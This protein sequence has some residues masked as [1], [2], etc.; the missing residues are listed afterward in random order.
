MSLIYLG[1]Y[2]KYRGLKV[3]I[4]DPTMK[5][6]V[7]DNKFYNHRDLLINSIRLS[8]IHEIQQTT[9]RYVGISC[10]SGEVEEVK[11][12]IGDIRRYSSAKIVVGG[13]HPTLNPLEFKDY[14]DE[15]VVGEGEVAL[16]N[17][18]MGNPPEEY[19][20]HDIESISH[21]DYSLIDVDYYTRPNPYSIRGMFLSTSY[22]LASRGCPASCKFCVAPRLRPYFGTGRYRDVFS[23]IK[24]IIHLRDTYHI[25]GFYFLDDYFTLNKKLVLE[26]CKYMR[27]L[28]TGLV[29]ACNSKVNIDE[30]LIE[31]VASAGC[32]QMDF[33]VERGSD[34][35][36][37]EVNK[38]QTVEQI[39]NTFRLC[40]KYGVRTF[41]NMLVNIKGETLEDYDDII[42]LLNEIKPTIFSVNNYVKYD[43][44]L[45]EEGIGQLKAIGTKEC[46]A[47]R[48]YL[49]L[50]KH[51][52]AHVNMRYIR[53]VWKSHKRIEYLKQFGLLIKEVF[54]QCRR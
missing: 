12:L 54:L 21:P 2:L 24:E 27:N 44:A 49:D 43:G 45:L 33:G 16:Y 7:R 52:R 36:L 39:K 26:F 10:Y 20:I 47:N 11:S 51:I 1:G 13:V 35:S 9:T 23:I 48:V 31:A 30:E 37:R 34:R 15:I 32:I 38:G 40:K 28:N 22:I 41:A 4:I 8:I 29:W 50:W 5:D 14:A 17:I 3:K 25:D 53:L 18:L 6:I 19:K 46:P 42:N